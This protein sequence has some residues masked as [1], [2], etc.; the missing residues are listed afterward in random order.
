[1]YYA[2]IE[3]LFEVSGMKFHLFP[4]LEYAAIAGTRISYN[5]YFL[6]YTGINWRAY[7]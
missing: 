3:D 5:D 4:I 2:W 1:M 6:D 7:L